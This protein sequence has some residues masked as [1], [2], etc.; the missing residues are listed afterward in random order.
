MVGH[1]RLLHRVGAA[2]RQVEVAGV[3]ADIDRRSVR[4]NAALPALL[5]SRHAVAVSGADGDPYLVW[6]IDP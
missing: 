3:A 4:S 5:A 2:L 6:R 1:E